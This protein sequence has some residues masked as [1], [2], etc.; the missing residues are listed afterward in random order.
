MRY[1]AVPRACGAL[2]SRADRGPSV[3]DF[4]VTQ[5]TVVFV[6]VTASPDAPEVAAGVKPVVVIL[7][8]AFAAELEA[9][10]ASTNAAATAVIKHFSDPSMHCVRHLPCYR[11]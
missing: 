11:R 5:P 10:R 3:S 9:G 2:K 6:H 7:T 8:V 4:S 1:L